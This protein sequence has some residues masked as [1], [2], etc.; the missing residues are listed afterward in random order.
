LK[1][2]HVEDAGGGCQAFPEVLVLVCESSGEIF[3][4]KMPLTWSD[5]TGM[6][7][8]ACQIMMS[9]MEK[10]G[11]CKEDQLL[12]CSGNIFHA[13]HQWLDQN[14]YL[15]E[16]SKIDG[17]AHEVAEEQ[18]HRQVVDAG[19]PEDIRL[20]ERNYRDYYRLLENWVAS[21]PDR[22]Q[23]YKDREVR[24]KPAETRYVLK[25]TGSHGRPCL[26]CRQKI[27][28][29]TPVVIYRTRENGRKIRRYY[30]PSCSP[31]EPLKTS[32]VTRT[33]DWNKQKIEGVILVAKEEEKKACAVCLQP[34]LPGEITFF[35]YAGDQLITGHLSCFEKE[36]KGGVRGA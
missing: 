3:S 32:L 27:R 34:I 1:L 28:P 8:K 23:Y 5:G 25:S 2:W 13:Y 14:S 24:R 18:F 22:H 30:H 15:W 33:V 9:L 6:E 4:E 20:V 31:V 19:F 26:S 36:D 17:L 21:N 10:A 29:Y 12:V 35:G 16:Q 11:V 7:E